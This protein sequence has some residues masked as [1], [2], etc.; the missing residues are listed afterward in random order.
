MLIANVGAVRLDGV[1]VEQMSAPGLELIV[2]ARHHPEWG[3]FDAGRAGRRADQKHS[4]LTILLPADISH[5]RAVERIL[6]MRGAKL[7]G[8][9]RGKPARDVDAV[10]EVV[11]KARRGDARGARHRGDRHQPADAAREGRG[12][13]RAR[14]AA[15]HRHPGLIRRETQEMA[16][17]TTTAEKPVPGGNT[18]S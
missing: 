5:A 18:C 13:G 10:A 17:M 15:R 9:F 8:A 6:A 4:T 7:L 16:T 14:C 12:R 2:G 11:V 3:A 1:L